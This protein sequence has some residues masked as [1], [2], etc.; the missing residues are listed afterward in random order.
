MSAAA[1]ALAKLRLRLRSCAAAPCDAR[2]HARCW[3]AYYNDCDMRSFVWCRRRQRGSLRLRE[4]DARVVILLPCRRRQYKAGMVSAHETGDV[5][6]HRRGPCAPTGRVRASRNMYTGAI[7]PGYVRS[8][9][10]IYTSHD[11]QDSHR[12]RDIHVLHRSSQ[13]AFCS[14]AV[15]AALI[16]ARRIPSYIRPRSRAAWAQV[17]FC[18]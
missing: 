4:I 2:T 10:F 12:P 3:R 18:S 6:G 1:A 5:G 11:P 9:T 13:Q 14:S 15:A 8:Y 16:I 17:P 7:C